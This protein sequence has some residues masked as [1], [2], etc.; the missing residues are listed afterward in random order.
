MW[1]ETRLDRKGKPMPV[2]RMDQPAGTSPTMVMLTDRQVSY[3]FRVLKVR[4]NCDHERRLLEGE[5]G[6]RKL[7]TDLAD[8]VGQR[9][10]F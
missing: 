6:K 5:C 1:E 10:M 2:L 3:W 4:G 7:S 8:T 9:L